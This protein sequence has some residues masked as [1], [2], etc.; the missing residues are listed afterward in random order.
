[1]TIRTWVYSKLS[2]DPIASEVGGVENPRVF[3]KKSMTSS[4]EEHP[5]IVYKLGN[6]TDDAFSEDV[7]VETQYIQIWVH[8]FTDEKSGDYMQIDRILGIIKS[9]FDKAVSPDDG[10]IRCIY[11][12]TS[13]DLDDNTLNTIF[14]YLRLAVKVKR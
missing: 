14:K 8:D 7:E 9:Q 5:F 12:E 11:L 4:I 2:S 6:N 10:V 3:A 13:Q 1:L